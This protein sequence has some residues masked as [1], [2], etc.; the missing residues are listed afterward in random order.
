MG[1]PTWSFQ[2]SL[3]K[4]LTALVQDGA[5]SIYQGHLLL[6]KDTNGCGLLQERFG[7]PLPSEFQ[8]IGS[9]LLPSIFGFIPRERPKPQKKF[10]L[11]RV[12][13]TSAPLLGWGIQKDTKSQF[14][15]V[16]LAS[17]TQIA[18]LPSLFGGLSLVE[19]TTKEWQQ[20]R[21]QSRASKLKVRESADQPKWLW[22][23]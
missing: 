23:S 4:Q 14:G 1:L 20:C 7:A 19:S 11:P 22:S 17:S 18:P 13:R 5:Y 10:R 3:V 15:M 8:A 12:S 2:V 21:I 6:Q 16:D 9:W